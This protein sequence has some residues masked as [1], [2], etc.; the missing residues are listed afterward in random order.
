MFRFL[1]NK[2]AMECS[3]KEPPRTSQNLNF[4]CGHEL[5][6][7][8]ILTFHAC[9]TSETKDKDTD[10]TT[11]YHNGSMCCSYLYMSSLYLSLL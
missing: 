4:S 1:A 2:Y 6:D 9:F 11:Y 7:R 3:R 10:N 8:I 5:S